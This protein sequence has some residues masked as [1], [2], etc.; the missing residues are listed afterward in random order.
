MTVSP[1]SEG[2][3]ELPN[4]NA[5]WNSRQMRSQGAQN[6]PSGAARG[7]LA[8]TAMKVGPAACADARVGLPMVIQARGEE[9]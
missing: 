6:V 8:R 3:P 9:G 4:R 5:Y 7:V 2:A 1:G